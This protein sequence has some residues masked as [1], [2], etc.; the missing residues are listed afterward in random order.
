LINTP[1][2]TPGACGQTKGGTG[3]VIESM[4]LP[5]GVVQF[6]I[7]FLQT[8][9]SADTHSNLVGPKML[10]SL[11]ICKPAAD[12]RWRVIFLNF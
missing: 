9:V 4:Q 1:I 8:I 5:V 10:S 6:F 12:G 3:K 11:Q 2:A 7:F